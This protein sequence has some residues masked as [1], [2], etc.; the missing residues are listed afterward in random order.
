MSST[1]RIIIDSDAPNIIIQGSGAAAGNISGNDNNI[2]GNYAANNITSGKSNN[3]FGERA[4]Y[5]L[6]TG[7]FNNIFGHQAAYYLTYGNYNIIMGY[8]AGTYTM[9]GNNNVFL[10]YYAGAMH[11][12][13]W[14]SH[15]IAIG[16]SSGETS[17]KKVNTICIGNGATVTDNNMCRIGNN[18]IK[19]GIGTSSPGNL[20]EVVGDISCNELYV[21]DTTKTNFKV[22]TTGDISGN[23]ASFNNIQFLGKILKEDGTELSGGSSYDKDTSITVYDVDICG[24]LIIGRHNQVKDMNTSPRVYGSVVIGANCKVKSTQAGSMAVGVNCEVGDWS[25]EYGSGADGWQA[26]A[27]GK[28]SKA[29]K[30]GSVAIGTNCVVENERGVALGNSAYVG[31]DI[32]FA[33]GGK[34]SSTVLASPPTSSS[35]LNK[36]EIDK[37]GNVDVY[38]TLTA[39]ETVETNSDDRIKHNEIDISNCLTTIKKLRPTKYFKTRE[40]YDVSHNFNLDSSGNPLDESGNIITSG[41]KTETGFIAQRV[42]EIEELQHLVRGENKKVLSLNYI[43]IIPYNTKAIQELDEIQQ[44]EKTKLA[45]TETKL[46][47]AEAKI[48]SLETQ[49]AQVLTRLDALESN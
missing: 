19:V 10:G 21:G 16:N 7:R 17:G 32:R 49:L 41:I 6:T 39:Y 8:Q 43:G 13:A 1:G 36:F 3:I 34:S 20:L 47:A 14:G 48:T 35:N 18:D 31:G 30:Q 25:Q 44:S 22:K 24:N 15:N 37:N 38:G 46:A 42:K 29:K 2:F 40:I 45:T 27:F 11:P 33:F 12:H 4:A 26:Y 9:S 5:E 23:D 28:D